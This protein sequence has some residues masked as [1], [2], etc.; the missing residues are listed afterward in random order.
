MRPVCHPN[1]HV[2]DIFLFPQNIMTL[3]NVC[4]VCL[5]TENYLDLHI[6]YNYVP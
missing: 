1:G 2:F 4:K 5:C 6:Q 3:Q